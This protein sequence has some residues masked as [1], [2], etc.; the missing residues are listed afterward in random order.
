MTDNSNVLSIVGMNDAPESTISVE[1]SQEK[2]FNKCLSCEYLGAGCSGPNLNAMTVERACEFLQIR[3]NQLGYTYQAVADISMLSIVTVKRILTGQVK[4]PGFMSM[5]A[6]TF[7]LV[8]DPKGKYPCAMH[9]INKE[10]EQA[11]AA[12]LA[13]QNALAQKEAEFE[14]ARQ[15]DRKKIDFLLEQIHFKEEQ[16]KAKDKQ[17]EDRYRFLKKKDYAI[18]T[19]SVFLFIAV[20]IILTALIVDRLN[21]DIG[22]F[23]IDRIWGRASNGEIGHM[24]EKLFA[25]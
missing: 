22:F 14:R 21:S 9:L 17:L 18:L 10:T 7:A 4:D 1:V 25:L 13:A 16:M 20:A 24:F 6:L 23:W 8:S 5:Q 19:L 2:P 11:T 3:R 12:C 15:E